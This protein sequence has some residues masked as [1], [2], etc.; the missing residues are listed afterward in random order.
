MAQIII[1]AS[2][3][4][5]RVLSLTR[6][7]FAPPDRTLA[8]IIKK[9]ML[10]KGLSDE[11]ISSVVY[12]LSVVRIRGRLRQAIGRGIRQKTDVSRIWIGDKI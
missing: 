2:A 6:I 10:K 9:S 1:E 7:P 5:V 11:I 3:S 8:D 12:G 4:G